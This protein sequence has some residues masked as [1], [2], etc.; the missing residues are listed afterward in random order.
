MSATGFLSFGAETFRWPGAELHWWPAAVAPDLADRWM[1]ALQSDIGW[2]EERLT[3]FGRQVLAPRLIAWH[4]DPDS[5]YRYSGVVHHPRPWTPLLSEIRDAV[6]QLASESFNSVLL[7]FYRHGQDS[8]GWHADDEPELGPEP[9][10]AS[11]SLGQARRMRFRRRRDHSDTHELVLSHGSLL[12]MSGQTQAN[13]H[14]AIPKT[15]R[16]PGPRIN[17][18]FRHITTSGPG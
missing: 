16:A 10:I 13:W 8:M 9:V 1:E 7:N 15:R 2:Q 12:V 17:L 18:T 4:G 11:L 14:H 5:R 6:Q 3:L